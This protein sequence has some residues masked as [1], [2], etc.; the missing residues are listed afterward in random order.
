MQIIPAID[1][2]D[3]QVVRLSQGKMDQAIVYG[4]DVLAVAK[5]WIDAGATRL[6]I[7]DLN[8]AFMG[9]PCH[10]KEIEKIATLKNIQVEVGGGIRNMTVLKQYMDCGVSFAILGTSVIT[11]QEFVFDACKLFPHQIILGVD[12]KNGMVMTQGWDDASGIRA[13]DAVKPFQGEN[14]ESLIYTDIASDGMLKGMNYDR[15]LDMKNSG[16]PIIASGGFSSLADLDRLSTMD[17]VK[18]VIAGKA[19]YEG[20]VDLKTAIARAQQPKK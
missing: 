5:R 19:I 13:L 20:V 12:A 8:G 14:I 1:L 15:L 11:D 17:F 7:V 3:H 6:H 10:F 18:G 4:D 2:K 9:N 16:F